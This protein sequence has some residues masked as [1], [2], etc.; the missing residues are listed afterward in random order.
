[1]NWDRIDARR[2]AEI[3]D[4]LTTSEEETASTLTPAIAALEE[5]WTY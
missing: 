3:L 2:A 5:M 4:S 1:M